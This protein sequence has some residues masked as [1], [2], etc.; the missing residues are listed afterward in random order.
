MGPHAANMGPAV[1]KKCHHWQLGCLAY[2]IPLAG[3]VHPGQRDGESSDSVRPS[4]ARYAQ[5][6]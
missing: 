3:W 1:P 4:R 6:T 5:I 2:D